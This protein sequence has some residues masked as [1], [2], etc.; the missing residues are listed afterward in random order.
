MVL[1]ARQAAFQHARYTCTWSPVA[2]P[3]ATAP[4]APS[5][6]APYSSLCCHDLPVVVSLMRHVCML[7]LCS[8]MILY[9]VAAHCS[10]TSLAP[11]TVTL[12]LPAAPPACVGAIVQLFLTQYGIP[13]LLTS[14]RSQNWPAGCIGA[15]AC[16]Q[17]A[18]LSVM[19]SAP[20]STCIQA[21]RLYEGFAAQQLECSQLGAGSSTM[22][23]CRSGCLVE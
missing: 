7:S 8:G 23:F 2:L 16:N 3:N 9:S 13:G 11:V 17:L 1:I 14:H 6:A 10:P 18:V 4:T 22:W 19:E 20:Q 5:T 21:M 15:S 12:K